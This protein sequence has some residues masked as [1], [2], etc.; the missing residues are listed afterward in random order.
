MLEIVFTRVPSPLIRSLFSLLRG[1]NE[2]GLVCSW[3]SFVF[4]INT[5]SV[6]VFSSRRELTARILLV[7]ILLSNHGS[8]LD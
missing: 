3:E 4:S 1:V 5:E 2:S 8:L 7:R 6:N